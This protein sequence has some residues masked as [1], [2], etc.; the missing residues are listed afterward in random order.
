LLS[1]LEKSTDKNILKELA[2]IYYSMG[3]YKDAERI[4]KKYESTYDTKPVE[5]NIEKQPIYKKP[6]PI[7]KREREVPFILDEDSNSHLQNEKKEYI[8]TE[9]N[10][11]FEKLNQ[12]DLDKRKYNSEVEI[13]DRDER[14][15]TQDNSEKKKISLK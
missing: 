15:L 7:E 12:S 9:N 2:T 14:F 4:I 8:T 13:V 10:D 1:S 3:R 6:A 11:K 5:E